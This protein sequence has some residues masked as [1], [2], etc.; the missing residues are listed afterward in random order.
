MR[1]L[2]NVDGRNAILRIHGLGARPPKSNRNRP[3]HT[4]GGHFQGLQPSRDGLPPEG[5]GCQAGQLRQ[6]CRD[7]GSHLRT[8]DTPGPAFT[9][10]RHGFSQR[11]EARTTTRSQGSRAARHSSDLENRAT[12]PTAPALDQDSY[13]DGNPPADFRIPVVD[14]PACCDPNV[15]FIVGRRK[16]RTRLGGR[17]PQFPESRRFK[18]GLQ[19]CE[20]ALQGPNR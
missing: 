16:T 9:F 4:G 15:W 19:G 20:A 13:H 6:P 3:Q 11:R 8:D 17:L 14:G 5:P 10:A 2:R 7:A 18:C 1:P 12:A